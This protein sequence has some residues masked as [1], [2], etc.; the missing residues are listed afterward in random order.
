MDG[1]ENWIMVKRLVGN[2]D[3]EIS[4]AF[5]GYRPIRSVDT[6]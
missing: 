5:D 1:G 6:F 2:G 3:G 4:L